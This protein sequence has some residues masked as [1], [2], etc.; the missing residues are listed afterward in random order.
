MNEGVNPLNFFFRD[1]A[2]FQQLSS[3]R[4]ESGTEIGE[5]A[6]IATSRLLPQLQLT[7]EGLLQVE[8]AV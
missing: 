2:S 3:S 8:L 1:R 5:V 7:V 6:E 4:D